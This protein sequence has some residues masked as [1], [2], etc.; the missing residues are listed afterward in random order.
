MHHALQHYYT[1]LS[2][3]LIYQVLIYINTSDTLAEVTGI[4]YLNGQ[5]LSATGF[6]SQEPIFQAGQI[7]E[8]TTTDQ[9]VVELQ[10]EVDE[11]SNINLIP[12]SP[13]IITTLITNPPASSASTLSLGTAYQ[14]TLGYDVMLTVYLSVT[15][16]LVGNILLGV[17]N[18]DSPDQQTIVSGI[19]LAA[20]SIVPIS[21]YL[22]ANYYAK[23]STSGTISA[24]I[25]GQIC[26][27]I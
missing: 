5:T 26:M 19:T 10:I 1:M 7:A 4:G 2:Q 23:L 24:S 16:A 18:N 3:V 12:L 13:I 6:F 15:S 14:N 22:P 8:V 25:I 20:L 11:L 9:G 27:S 21:I 17:G